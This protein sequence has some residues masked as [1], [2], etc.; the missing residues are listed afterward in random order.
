MALAGFLHIRLHPIANHLWDL[1]FFY[2]GLFF[3]VAYP[4]LYVYRWKLTDG[5]LNMVLWP[6][7]FV[8][9]WGLGISV[10]LWIVYIALFW[11]SPYFSS[12]IHHQA[13]LGGLF[14]FIYFPVIQPL[15]GVSRRYH[16]LGELVWILF[17]TG[18][19]G[20]VGFLLGHFVDGKYALSIGTDGHR[21]LLWLA[22]IFL[23]AAIGALVA[24]K[25]AQK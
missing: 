21:F 13:V 15:L 1:N 22:L 4:L 24:Q 6:L 7:S 12:L 23:G 9:S 20:F 3:L 14:A 5:C 11:G 8:L 19:G 10:Y 16:S 2:N 17:Y 18:L 25:Q